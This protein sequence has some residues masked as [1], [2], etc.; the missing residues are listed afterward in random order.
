MQL[1]TDSAVKEA[2]DSSLPTPADSETDIFGDD[3]MLQELVAYRKYY[4]A[5]L[6]EGHHSQKDRKTIQPFVLRRC[7][8]Q[9]S[10]IAQ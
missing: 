5:N 7:L 10:S 9:G 8:D 6:L 4:R 3:G 1:Q 2:A